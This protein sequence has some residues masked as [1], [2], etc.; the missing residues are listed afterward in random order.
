[1]HR[2]FKIGLISGMVVVI[3]A[4]IYLATRP[5]LSFKRLHS[6]S[7][8][9]DRQSPGPL[10]APLS[11][12]QSESPGEDPGT[13]DWTAYEQ[14]EKVQTQKFHIV[15]KRETLSDVA[16]Q[17]YGSPAKWQKIYQANRDTVTNPNALRPGTKLILPE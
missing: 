9:A 13:R 4:T 1:M 5:D 16:R 8:S 3:A 15:R 11:A 17:Y 10:P 12:T 14:P 6:R 7:S 2:D